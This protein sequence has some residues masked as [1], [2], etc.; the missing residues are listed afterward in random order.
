MKKL[1]VFLDTSV[2]SAM[3][4]DR[5]PAR[6][7]QTQDF[8]KNINDYELFYSQINIE[9]IDAI[10]NEVI[11][12]KLKSH[13]KKGKRIEITNEVKLLT[14]VYIKEGLIPEKYESDAILLALTTVHSLDILISWNFKHLVKRKTRIGVNLINLKEGYKTIEILA[15]PE[16]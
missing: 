7:T 6:Q 16:L 2:Y 5:D 4:D 14:K 1:K 15:P 8:W 9:E 12:N 13:V 10:I 3:L 11:K